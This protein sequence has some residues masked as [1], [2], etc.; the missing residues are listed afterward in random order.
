MKIHLDIQCPFELGGK[1]TISSKYFQLSIPHLVAIFISCKSGYT[2]RDAQII[3]I[4]FIPLLLNKFVQHSETKMQRMNGMSLLTYPHLRCHALKRVRRGLQRYSQNQGD[5][6][7][8]MNVIQ[9]YRASSYT[10]PQNYRII[11]LFSKNKGH[12]IQDTIVRK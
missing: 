11:G 3:V 9:R 12:K 7:G 6:V 8:G 5:S 2:V 4:C 10:T 1:R